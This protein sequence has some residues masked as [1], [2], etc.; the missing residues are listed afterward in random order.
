MAERN[1]NKMILIIHITDWIILKNPEK[2][3]QFEILRKLPNITSLKEDRNGQ[4][5][6]TKN[7]QD[8]NNNSNKPAYNHL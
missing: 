5:A 7:N 1:D 4:N 2:R 6:V 3:V 8:K